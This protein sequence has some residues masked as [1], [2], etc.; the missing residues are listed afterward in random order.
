MM[1]KVRTVSAANG[2]F[3]VLLGVLSAGQ[4]FSTTLYDQNVTP[5][6]LFGSGNANGSFTIDQA[7]GIELGLRGK[8]RHDATGQPQN[9]FNSNGDGSYTFKSGVAPTQSSPTGVWSIE[10]SINTDYLG[11]SGLALN[12]L[13]YELSL[14]TDPSS[15]VSFSTFDPI[16]GTNP[17]TSTVYWDHAIGDNGDTAATNFNA[18]DEVD[19]ASLIDTY[20]VAQNSWKAHWIIPGFDPTVNGEYT[21]SLTA[22]DGMTAL[23]SSS[24]VINAVPEPG[25][26]ALVGLSSL[27]GSAVYLRRRWR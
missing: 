5:G 24:I 19:Y 16:N 2:V 12:D 11:T 7:N 26:I 17:N 14:D 4:A 23:A 10:W 27:F 20:N 13:R 8:L 9:I 22:F 25:T 15:G 3:A 1:L 6:I 21:V 18:S